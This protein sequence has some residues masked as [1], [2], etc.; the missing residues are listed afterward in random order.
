MAGELRVET[1][2]EQDGEIRLRGLPY[3]KGQRVEMTVRAVQAEKEVRP[4]LTARKLLSSGL[5]GMWRDREDIG[6]SVAYARKLRER[7]QL[8]GGRV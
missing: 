2:V 7:A 5:I 3:K 6:D 4:A 1:V 8:R